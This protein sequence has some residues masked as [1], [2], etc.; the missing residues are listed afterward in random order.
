M[1][2]PYPEVYG[3]KIITLNRQGF[4][5]EGSCGF[6][7]DITSIQLCVKISVLALKSFSVIGCS[8]NANTRGFKSDF[9]CPTQLHIMLSV[10]TSQ[11]CFSSQWK[12]VCKIPMANKDEIQTVTTVFIRNIIHVGFH[13]HV[14]SAYLNVVSG[15]K[16]IIL[17]ISEGNAGWI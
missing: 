2:A 17:D 9:S 8:S 3:F 1:S 16:L 14:P 15:Q 13:E 10:E 7:S 5:Y 11:G 4:A 12:I 6:Y